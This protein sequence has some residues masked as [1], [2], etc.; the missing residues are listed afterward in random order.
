MLNTIIDT[1]INSGREEEE[2]FMD[3]IMNRQQSKMNSTLATVMW[4]IRLGIEIIFSVIVAKMA[5]ACSGSILMAV[6]AFVFPQ[7][8][9]IY[10]VLAGSKCAAYWS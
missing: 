6:L 8:F 10:Y 9:F 4:S 2:Q 7:L 3:D 1:F 5:M